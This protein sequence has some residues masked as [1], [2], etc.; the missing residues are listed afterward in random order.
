MLL[1]MWPPLPSQGFAGREIL[2]GV[3]WVRKPST[4]LGCSHWWPGICQEPPHVPLSL[5]GCPLGMS[6]S[7]PPPLGQLFLWATL[8]GL[9][10]LTAAAGCRWLWALWEHPGWSRALELQQQFAWNG[11]EGEHNSVS[12]GR[13]AAGAAQP[14]LEPCHHASGKVPL[15]ALPHQQLASSVG[16]G[17]AGKAMPPSASTALLERSQASRVPTA[18]GACHNKAPWDPPPPAQAL[19]H[20]LVVP[21]Q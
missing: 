16:R 9:T 11:A 17:Q 5:G 2:T 3:G 1:S 7:L 6:P 21:P 10:A 20:R 14:T 18:S 12:R 8:R 19:S 4:Q 15:G 13:K